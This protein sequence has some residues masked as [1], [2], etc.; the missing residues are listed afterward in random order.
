MRGDMFKSKKL[1][2]PECKKAKSGMCSRENII[3][4]EQIR[5]LIF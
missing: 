1:A 4:K 2:S 3:L 5:M